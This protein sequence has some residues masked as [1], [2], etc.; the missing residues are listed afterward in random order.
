MSDLNNLRHGCN[1]LQA[2]RTAEEL[3]V[4]VLKVP[5]TGEYRFRHPSQSKTVRCDGRRK[6]AP[7]A[8][9]CYLR[10]VA[11]ALGRAA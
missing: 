11:V 3:G 9:T 2:I 4:V 6:D 10:K 5:G 1:L 8:V 7:R